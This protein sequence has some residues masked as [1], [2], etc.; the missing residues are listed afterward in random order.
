MTMHHSRWD[1]ALI[2]TLLTAVIL[3]PTLTDGASIC[4]LS[5]QEWMELRNS[6]AGMVA[7]GWGPLLVRLA[8]ADAGTYSIVD[9]TGGARGTL[10]LVP[11]S[12]G[13]VSLQNSIDALE[14]IKE[15]YPSI[16]YAD[17]WA[18]AGT[19]ASMDTQSAKVSPSSKGVEF[20][21]SEH[22]TFSRFTNEFFTLLVSSNSNWTAVVNPNSK[23]QYNNSDNT[24]MMLVSDYALWQDPI[25]REISLQYAANNSLFYQDFTSAYQ[26]LLERG[27]TLNSANN[28]TVV[29]DA[30]SRVRRLSSALDATLTVE[31]DGWFAFG[32][33]SGMPSQ[34]IYAYEPDLNNGVG[35]I[36]DRKSTA[37]A[38]PSQDIDLGG[39]SSVENFVDLTSKKGD[40]TWLK[41]V[42]FSRKLVTGDPNDND[43][44]PGITTVT[45]A[46]SLSHRSIAYHGPNKAKMEI[47]FF[48][49]YVSTNDTMDPLPVLQI[50]HGSLMLLCFGVLM[51][52]AIF[53]ARNSTTYSN[54][55]ELHEQVC[56]FI[57]TEVFISGVLAIFGKIANGQLSIHPIIGLILLGVTTW[58]VL[59]GYVIVHYVRILRL[60]Q[61]LARFQAYIRTLHIVAGYLAYFTALTNGYLGVTDLLTHSISTTSAQV[62]AAQALYLI[63]VLSVPVFMM[64]FGHRRKVYER[65]GRTQSAVNDDELTKHKIKNAVDPVIAKLVEMTWKDFNDQ[66]AQGK[67]YIVIKDV[68]Y[69][70]ASN[71]WM[72]HH[73]GG[74]RILQAVVGTDCTPYFT[75]DELPGAGRRHNHSRVAEFQLKGLACGRIKAFA[76]VDPAGNL[77]G[78]DIARLSV[79]KT[80]SFAE[81]TGRVAR[82]PSFTTS[83]VPLLQLLNHAYRLLPLKEKKV[84]SSPSA[85]SKVYQCSL[86]L[87]NPSAEVTFA[88]GDHISIQLSSAEGKLIERPYTPIKSLCK[89]SI[90]FIV[91]IRTKGEFTPLLD[92]T[93]AGSNIRVKFMRGGEDGRN[94]VMANL[95][96]PSLCFGNVGMVSSGIGI[97]PMMQLIDYYTRNGPRLENGTPAFKLWLTAIFETE[98]DVVGRELIEEHVATLGSA[99]SLKVV[100]RHLDGA[101]LPWV[102]DVKETIDNELLSSNLPP[103]PKVTKSALNFAAAGE[104][105]K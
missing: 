66:I 80:K 103:P 76:K 65:L 34:D 41:V 72:N 43:I 30:T 92:R 104:L 81:E 13:H 105:M 19:V 83:D 69:D 40:T 91:R 10:K 94:P 44:S 12:G 86:A 32:I 47:D 48:S 98:K 56:A 70:L 97:T 50:I 11:P 75:G 37:F 45:Y 14:L 89:G 28:V 93:E 100:I 16:G 68:V 74:L 53:V 59:S 61:L 71:D 58:S 101:K 60:G 42:G 55:L 51:P 88:P 54:W 8:W 99:L 67:K 18:F 63:S 9:G 27:A 35:G 7:A 73:P 82:T 25:Y 5:A 95:S 90:P 1:I 26:K 33:G 21:T 17:L 62:A 96:H 64:M 85:S 38:V 77:S 84:L 6:L 49:A 20:A 22:P 46:W 24:L 4:G 78:A 31:T 15:S 36:S 79:V 2:A 87:P 3:I 57:Y 52:F 29:G 39:S 102:S 23:V